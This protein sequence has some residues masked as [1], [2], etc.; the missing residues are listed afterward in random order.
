MIQGH[1]RNAFNLNCPI[2]SAL[3]YL[4]HFTQATKEM[5]LRKV[6]KKQ[7]K[8]SIAKSEF[9]E[10]APISSVTVY[11]SNEGETTWEVIYNRLEDERPKITIT[12][13]T[14]NST[15]PLGLQFKDVS[16]SFLHR[17][18]ARA[19]I[20]P[21]MDMILWVVE[22]LTIEDRQFRNSRNEVM[23]S[24]RAEDMENVSYT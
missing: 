13:T 4:V 15:R 10:M 16:C 18:G 14:I 20:L 21:Y 5:S 2:L 22:N 11:S 23:G 17:I 24:F 19:K 12:R 9:T 8:K 3:I 1:F 7:K 6:M